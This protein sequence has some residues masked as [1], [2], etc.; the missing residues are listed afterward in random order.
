MGHHRRVTARDLPF[1]GSALA[2]VK[3]PDWNGA[4][5]LPQRTEGP[6]RPACGGAQVEIR[7]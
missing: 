3:S 1:E 6:E 7:T 2:F 5:A 4:R